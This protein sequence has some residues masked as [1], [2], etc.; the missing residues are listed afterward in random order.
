MMAGATDLPVLGRVAALA[1]TVGRRRCRRAIEPVLSPLRERGQTRVSPEVVRAHLTDAA[2]E[3]MVAAAGHQLAR[4]QLIV[5]SIP[6]VLLLVP[7]GVW[8][9]RTML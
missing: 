7:V 2:C 3:S 8:A 4:W 5:A 9:Y 1:A 6:L